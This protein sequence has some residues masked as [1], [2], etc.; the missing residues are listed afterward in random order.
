MSHFTS[1]LSFATHSAGEH[2]YKRDHA[3]RFRACVCVGLW[4]GGRR[5]VAHAVPHA[6]LY[7]SDGIRRFLRGRLEHGRT[8]P[9]IPTGCLPE[10]LKHELVWIRTDVLGEQAYQSRQGSSVTSLSNP[11]EANAIV[12]VLHRLDEYQPFLDWL[13]KQPED[14]KPVGIICTYAEQRELIRRKLLSVSIS[15]ILR[16]A[17]KIDTVDSYQG[18]ENTIVILSL[19]RNNADGRIEAG[20]PTIVQGF[21]ARGNRVNVALSRAMDRLVIVGASERWPDNSPM[22]RVSATV[23]E[24]VRE[25]AAEFIDAPALTLDS[26]ELGAK[27]VSK[28]RVPAKEEPLDKT[29]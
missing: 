4:K 19:V 13:A 6:A 14:E 8:E 17:C 24:L 16:N 18:K 7:W 11:V 2:S 3:Q 28:K 23:A 5:D 9:K 12:D 22:A 20:R 27:R 26:G 25:G 21:M 29:S 15:G 1:P 10:L